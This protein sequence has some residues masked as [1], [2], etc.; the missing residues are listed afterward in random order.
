MR[1]YF[2]LIIMFLGVLTLKAQ[3]NIIP[4]PVSFQSTDGM[5]MLDNQTSI[6]LKANNPALRKMAE[7]FQMF[8]KNAGT[9]INFK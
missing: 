4:A 8:L 2:F 3:Q 9:N 1:N 6:D 7:N 5:F